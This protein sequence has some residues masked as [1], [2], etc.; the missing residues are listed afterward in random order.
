MD[1]YYKLK[2]E[3]SC[4]DCKFP[5]A[6]LKDIGYMSY[7]AVCPACRKEYEINLEKRINKNEVGR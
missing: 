1:M 4:D 7:V 6:Y 3:L 2:D 5:L